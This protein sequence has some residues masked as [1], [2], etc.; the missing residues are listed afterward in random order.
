MTARSPMSD[1]PPAGTD[2]A[3]AVVSAPT[4]TTPGSAAVVCS[5]A[6]QE[7]GS[8][9]LRAWFAAYLSWLIVLTAGSLICLHASR[10]GV[11]G[12][13]P[14]WLACLG[15][16]Y[17]S[18]ANG[19]LPL[20]TM[21]MIMLLA[22]DAVGL[23][24]SPLARVVMVATITAVATGMAN[25]NEYHVLHWALGS[26]TAG[27]V[28]NTRLVQWAIRWFRVSPFWILTMAALVPI[29][30]D[31][32]RWVAIADSYNRLRFFWAYALGRWVR[33]AVL[34]GTTI[35]LHAGVRTII[36]TQVALIVVAA[37]P[38]VA[39]MMRQRH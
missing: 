13:I 26:R 11:A 36:V 14:V 3:V 5:T 17:L 9:T 6:T 20:P 15:T 37:A 31:A 32:I 38:V 24:G 29:P 33:Y 27:K 34:A 23:P 16:F 10:Q 39:K 12:A 8:V 22:S 35:W 2:A 1:T 21:W 28:T 7:M 4:P 30:I 19:L 25:L 18:L